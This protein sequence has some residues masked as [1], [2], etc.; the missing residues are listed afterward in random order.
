MFKGIKIFIL[1]LFL[2]LVISGIAKDKF[3]DTPLN[4]LK[5]LKSQPAQNDIDTNIF[6]T[7]KT[8]VYKMYFWSIIPMGELRYSAQTKESDVVFSFEALTNKSFVERFITAHASVESYF[9]KKDLLP[10]KYAER[11]EVNGKVKQKEVLYDRINLLSVQGDKKIKIYRDTYDPVGAFVHML[12][13]SLEPNKDYNIPFLS[14][15]DMYI[16]KAK[17]LNREHG[18]DEVSI[19]MRRQNLTSSHG[20]NLHVWI[21][22]DNNRIPV[23]FKSWTPVGY[24]SVVLDKVLIEQKGKL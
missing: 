14:G 15:Y 12:S 11:T 3:L 20:G 13:L 24:A 8:L 21:T 18:I 9:S 17:L 4:C 10:Y 22:A 23:L 7:N 2:V 19:D 16:F 5:K 1:E 6:K